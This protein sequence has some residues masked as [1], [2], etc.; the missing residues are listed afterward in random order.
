MAISFAAGDVVTAA[1]INAFVPYYVAMGSDQATSTSVTDWNAGALSFAAGQ[2]WVCD[3]FL[4]YGNHSA[5]ANDFQVQYAAPTGGLTVP[6]IYSH[7]AAGAAAGVIAVSGSFQGRVSLT[8]SIAYGGTASTS[9]R[10]LAHQTFVVT[11]TTA[12]T[13]TPRVSVSAGTGTL[14][15]SSF[16]ICHRVS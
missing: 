3:L 10:G 4:E 8:T 13:L 7:G 16:V 5:A 6:R 11:T 1:K 9:I 14:Y 15:A 2:T 12:G